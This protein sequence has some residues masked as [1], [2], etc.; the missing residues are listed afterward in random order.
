MEAAG[1]REIELTGEMAQT[2][3]ETRRT[4]YVEPDE[5]RKGTASEDDLRPV[6]PALVVPLET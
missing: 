4:W 1:P 6:S 2:A 5:A 3:R